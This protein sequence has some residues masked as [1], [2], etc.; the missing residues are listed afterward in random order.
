MN[1]GNIEESPMKFDAFW[2]QMK[3]SKNEILQFWLNLLEC[4]WDNTEYHYT[5]YEVALLKSLVQI[6]VTTGAGRNILYG[7]RFY[8]EQVSRFWLLIDVI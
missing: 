1:M 5:K 8:S 7:V 4:L 2:R 6:N 3:N